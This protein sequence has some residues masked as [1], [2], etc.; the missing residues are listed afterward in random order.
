MGA[1]PE[2]FLIEAPNVVGQMGLETPCSIRPRGVSPGAMTSIKCG[3][4]IS[5]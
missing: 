4:A 5:V 1:H 3:S 2:F